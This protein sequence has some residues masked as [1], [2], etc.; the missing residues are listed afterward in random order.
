MCFCYGILDFLI[1]VY[2]FFF[3]FSDCLLYWF[4]GN[5]EFFVVIYYYL[6]VKRVLKKYMYIENFILIIKNIFKFKF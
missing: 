5:F 3:Y 6:W 1:N 4:K 2:F